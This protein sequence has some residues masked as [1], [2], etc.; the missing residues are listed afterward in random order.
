MGIAFI[1]L[2][3]SGFTLV[4]FN[5][6]L[7]TYSNISKFLEFYKL[8]PVKYYSKLKA[9]YI[10]HGNVMLKSWLWFQKSVQNQVLKRKFELISHLGDLTFIEKS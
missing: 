2:I 10:V 8:L 4:Y 3:F 7:M 6:G 1:L 9:F 5:T